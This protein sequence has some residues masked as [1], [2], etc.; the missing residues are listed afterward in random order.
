MSCG[1]LVHPFK[2]RRK[3]GEMKEGFVILWD[4]HG[5]QT[6][7]SFEGE[8]IVG[9]ELRLKVALGLGQATSDFHLCGP[10]GADISDDE[11]IPAGKSAS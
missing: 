1:S 11:D 2:R 6:T 8:G 9:R 5:A 10:T 4:Q 7:L 3:G